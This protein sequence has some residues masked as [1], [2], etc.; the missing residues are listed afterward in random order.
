[1][2]GEPKRDS[3]PPQVPLEEVEASLLSAFWTT[4]SLHGE[5]RVRLNP[6]RWLDRARRTWD[7]DRS[8]PH[9]VEITA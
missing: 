3:F 9:S 1:M 7:I 5:A 4:Q 8:S 2:T 6:A